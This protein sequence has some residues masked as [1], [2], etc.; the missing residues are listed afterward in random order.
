MVLEDLSVSSIILTLKWDSLT[1][2][3]EISDRVQVCW[4]WQA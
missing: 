4:E 3:G 1:W 2:M